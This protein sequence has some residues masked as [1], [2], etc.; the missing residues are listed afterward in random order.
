MHCHTRGS[1]GSGTPEEFVQAAKRARLDGVIVTD[2]H[3]TITEEGA[4]VVAALREAG[5]FAMLGC[6]YSCEEGHCLVYGVDVHDLNLGKY[7]KMSVVTE[8]VQKAG[9]VAIPAH[10]Y[11]GYR[12]R[13][14]DDVYALNDIDHVEVLNGQNQMRGN[15]ADKQAREAA[16]DLG[17]GMVGGSDAHV[18]ANLGVCFT[19]FEGVIRTEREFLDALRGGK[20]RARRNKKLLKERIAAKQFYGVQKE[21]ARVSRMR[22]MDSKSDFWERWKLTDGNRNKD[23][24]REV[25]KDSA[26]EGYTQGLQ[27]WAEEHEQVQ[28]AL[29]L[30]K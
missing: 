3:K 12:S 4:A 17:Y 30:V 2:H 29:V 6:E 26:E 25:Q 23:P 16:S 24:D 8:R 21:R 1:D 13:L 14:G 27:Q 9:G 28:R 20:F 19:E 5:I 18:A 7:P 10:P 11:K 22:A 15:D